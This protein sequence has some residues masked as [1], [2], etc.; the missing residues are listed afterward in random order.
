[1]KIQNPASPVIR[2]GG[3]DALFGLSLFR[4]A[5]SG[6]GVTCVGDFRL[7]RDSDGSRLL[8]RRR[9]A[10]R[11]FLVCP[12]SERPQNRSEQAGSSDGG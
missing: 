4:G 6:S 12:A 10:S 5:T 8:D 2:V 7:V 9:S 1:M 11:G 3:F